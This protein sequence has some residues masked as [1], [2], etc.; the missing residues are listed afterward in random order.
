MIGLA[1]HVARSIVARDERII[2]TGA[3]GWLGRA[4][5]ALLVEALG[6]EFER[7]VLCFG[8]AERNIALGARTVRQRALA[9]LGDLRPAPSWMLHL[10]FLTKDRAIAMEEAAY[11]AANRAI[12][13]QVV[14]A[15]DRIGVTGLFVPSSGAAER[16]DDPAASDAMRLYGGMKRDDERLFGDW[17]RRAGATAAIV[18][19][20]NV[21]GPYINKLDAY[22]LAALTADALRGDPITIR[23]TRPVLRSFA[24]IAE[25]MSVIFALLDASDRA[26]TTFDTAGERIVELDELARIVKAVTRSDM[27]IVR[28]PLNGGG[29]DRY[30]GARA[31]YEALLDRFSVPKASLEQ[32]VADTAA[33]IGAVLGAPAG[34]MRV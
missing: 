20:F 4:T 33:Y 11:I 23:A 27:S 29:A 3:S 5:L 12:S 7:R 26:I 30:A 21:T 9:E 8:S 34:S 22:A 32:Q 19:I 14:T 16:A 10:A 25:L 1:A 24:A 6:D 18:R 13:D 28:A 15:L 31:P 2:V 17:A